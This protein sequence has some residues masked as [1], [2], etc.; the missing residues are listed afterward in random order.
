MQRMAAIS[1]RP[2]PLISAALYAVLT[3]SLLAAGC[4][5]VKPEEE[6]PA[7][8]LARAQRLAA[9]GKHADAAQLYA[10]LASQ[11]PAQHDNYE[12]LSAEQWVLAGNT[13]AAR[14]A[15]AAVSPEAR[16]TL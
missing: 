12:L 10:E 4:S 9:D 11:T 14:Q 1:R 5:L 6:T 3:V 2:R 7:S 13:S 15:Y 8:T 16:T